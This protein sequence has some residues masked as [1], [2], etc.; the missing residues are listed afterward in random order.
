MN[1]KNK[2]SDDELVI[3]H[4]ASYSDNKNQ[5]F[6]LQVLKELK[7]LHENTRLNLVG[8]SGITPYCQKL[9]DYVKTN[10]LEKD[11]SFID[12]SDSV[13]RIYEK[14]TFVIIP[15][16]RE[17]F[18]LVAIEAQA[19]GIELFASSN[20]PKEIDCGGAMFIE[21]SKGPV[22]WAKEIYDKYL[23]EGNVRALLETNIFSF[24]RFKADLVTLYK[25]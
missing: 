19:C 21:L 8:A 7:K 5:L 15:S 13:E 10:D 12:K 24:N 6:S 16:L 17:G 22:F 3:T 25:L 4:V 2:L 11:V 18:S 23:H 9:I 14:T 1:I 20:V